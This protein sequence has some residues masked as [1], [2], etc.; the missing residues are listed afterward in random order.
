MTIPTSGAARD[1]SIASLSGSSQPVEVANSGRRFLQV[2]NTGN[3]NIGLNYCGGTAVIGGTGTFTI[4]PGDR[5]TLDWWVPT[6]AI[7]VI[8]TASQPVSIAVG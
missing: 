1:L 5:L 3:A 4:A 6:N 7:A 8:G 2:E